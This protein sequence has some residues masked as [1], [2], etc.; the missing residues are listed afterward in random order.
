MLKTPMVELLKYMELSNEEEEMKAEKDKMER[1]L[2]YLSLVH[3]NPLGDEKAR[4]KFIELIKPDKV[5]SKEIPKYE[6]D[7]SLLQRLKASQEGGKVIG[8]D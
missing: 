2:D 7:V 8:N 4:K 3:S 6:T 5:N 1:W